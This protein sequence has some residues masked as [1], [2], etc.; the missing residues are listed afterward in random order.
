[1]TITRKISIT[2]GAAELS[3][4][5]IKQIE[6]EIVCLERHLERLKRFDGFVEQKT[7]QTYQ[8]MIDARRAMLK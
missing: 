3:E 1:M 7:Y 6:K 2:I 5:Q 8:E 4:T